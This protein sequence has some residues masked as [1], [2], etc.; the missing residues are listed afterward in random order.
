MR[1]KLGPASQ[2]AR[3]TRR[4]PVVARPVDGPVGRGL[5]PLPAEC[6]ESAG[7]MHLKLTAGDRAVGDLLSR[8][9]GELRRDLEAGG[10]N[11]GTLDIGSQQRSVDWVRTR[12]SERSCPAQ[13]RTRA[14]RGRRA[15][16]HSPPLTGTTARHDA[17]HLIH[18]RHRRSRPS[19]LTPE[20]SWPSSSTSV[21]PTPNTTSLDPGT[22]AAATSTTR[23]STAT[24]S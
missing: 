10:T 4:P 7:V 5:G 12:R 11:V 21:N 1:A 20:P 22:T 16:G 15:A 17:H 13:C 24:P 23:R 9:G 14:Q 2:R 19:H 3:D 6:A 18:D 8:A